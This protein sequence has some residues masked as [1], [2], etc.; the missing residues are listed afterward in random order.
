VQVRAGQR[1]GQ[2]LRRQRP[3]AQARERHSRRRLR[4]AVPSPPSVRAVVVVGRYSTS[5]AAREWIPS[6]RSHVNN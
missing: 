5:D 2:V 4:A 6:L 1:Q 3:R